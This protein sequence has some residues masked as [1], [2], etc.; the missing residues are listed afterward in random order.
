MGKAGLGG[1][2]RVLLPV[3]VEKL[4][5]YVGWYLGIVMDG[6]SFVEVVDGGRVEVLWGLIWFLVLDHFGNVDEFFA[7]FSLFSTEPV[8]YKG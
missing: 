2:S 7:C 6:L 8:N 4:F 3:I 1:L 5:H